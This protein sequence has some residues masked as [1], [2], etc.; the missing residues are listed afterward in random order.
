ML[1]TLIHTKEN[2]IKAQQIQKLLDT[3]ISKSDNQNEKEELKKLLGFDDLNLAYYT[4]LYGK[5][6]ASGTEGSLELPLYIHEENVKSSGDV[7]VVYPTAIANEEQMK[8]LPAVHYRDLVSS[9]KKDAAKKA[10]LWIKKMQAGTGSSM[11]RNSYLASELGISEDSVKI[12]AKGT[13]LFIQAGA[14]KK[15]SIAEAQVLQAIADEKK[16][17]FGSV[18]LH[19]IVSSETEESID[20]I[21]GKKCLLEPE[22]DY[23][24]VIEK[25][26]GVQYFGKSFQSHI[27]TLDQNDNI[28]FNRVAPGGHALFGVDALMAAYRKEMRPDVG[29]LSLVSSVGNGEDLSSSPDAYM[30]NWMVEDSIP[31][32]MV[33][34][35]KTSNDMKGGQIAVVPGNKPYVTMMEK[36]QA[37]TSNQL[38]LFE[39]LGLRPGDN[40]AFFNTNMVLLNYSALSPKIEKLVGEIGEDEF[41]KIIAPDLIQN[42]KAQVDTDGVERTYLQLEGAMGTVVLN[43]DRYWREHFGEPIVHF[44]NVDAINRTQFFCP[45]KTAFDYFMQFHSDRFAFDPN[46][47]RLINLNPGELPMVNLKAKEYKDVGTVLSLFNKSRIKHLKELNVTGV[48][49]FCG[50]ELVGSID[51]VNEGDVVSVLPFADDGRIKDSSLQM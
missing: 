36:A 37:E 10:A 23:R 7:E 33:T 48:A 49:D 17:I 2:T 35:T 8:M 41:L 39:S 15:I 16:G 3:V 42:R 11:T 43:L 44:L 29:E 46:T 27:P 19:D 20:S 4:A 50:V 25:L 22:S 9:G 21:W 32:A 51:V 47:F 18:V 5:Y 34:T 26:K 12:G 14:N 24:A 6:Q 40:E 31:I 1:N 45:I 30:V 38:P 28:S 13:D